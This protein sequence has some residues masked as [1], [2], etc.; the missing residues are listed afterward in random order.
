M[1]DLSTG[2]HRGVKKRRAKTVENDTL[3]EI[4][5]L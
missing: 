5:V 3:P 2:V 1:R 4:G